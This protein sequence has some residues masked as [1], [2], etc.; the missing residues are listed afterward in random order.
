MDDK[1]DDNVS[2]VARVPIDDDTFDVSVELALVTMSEQLASI[3][4]FQREWIAM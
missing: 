2:E 3:E 1:W 4:K